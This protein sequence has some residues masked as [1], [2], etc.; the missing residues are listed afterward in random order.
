MVGSVP[1]IWFLFA[2]GMSQSE[3]EAGTCRNLPGAVASWAGPGLVFVLELLPTF[4]RV[5]SFT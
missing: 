4:L 2:R 1:L 3:L 5:G